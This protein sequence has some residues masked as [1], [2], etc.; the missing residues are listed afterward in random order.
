MLN[1]FKIIF[2]KKNDIEDFVRLFFLY[3]GFEPNF[4]SK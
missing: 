2:G 1:N 4:F 3:L